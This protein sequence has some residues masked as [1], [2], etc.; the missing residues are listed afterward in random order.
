[1]VGESETKRL[2]GKPRLG[3]EDDIK[4]NLTRL[5]SSDSS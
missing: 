1:L 2:F 4:I 3:W 5:D